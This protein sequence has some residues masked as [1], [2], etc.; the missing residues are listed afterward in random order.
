MLRSTLA[1]LAFAFATCDSDPIDAVFAQ[2]EANLGVWTFVGVEGARCRDGSATGFGIRLQ[3]GA[4]NL[5]IYLE[6]GGA[7]FNA[8]TCASNPSSFNEADFDALAAQR[9]NAGIFSTGSG[10]PVGDWNMVYVPYCTGDIHGGS[11][12]DATV[13]GVEGTHQ[14]V[15]HRNVERYLALLAPYLGDPDKVLLTGASAGGF[16]ALVNFAEVADRFDGSE[17]YLLDDSGPIFFAD[18]VL[19][20]QLAATF[21]RTWSLAAAFPADA[22][23]LFG[24]DGLEDA[25]AYY[26]DRYP[27]A[28]FGLSSHL[29]DATIRYFFGFGQPDGTITGEEFETG[30]RD[31]QTRLP[32]RWG[33]YYAEAADHTFIGSPSR[34]FG[35]SAGVAMNDW[36][37]DLLEG[38]RTH[39]VPESARLTTTP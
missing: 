25:Y 5:M 38:R 35:T 1:A 16:G 34:F 27:D 24:P 15:G 17:H 18:D 4:E 23:P 2:A 21:N 39:V 32:A 29:Q 6:G 10:N 11:V 12:E 31:L 19:S 20:P 26:A 9:G 13:E 36:L 14:F 8:E 33:V 37:G 22:A 3:E 28:A 7:C 30:L